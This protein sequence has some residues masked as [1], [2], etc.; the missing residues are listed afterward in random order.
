VVP[1]ATVGRVRFYPFN[2]GDYAAATR[3]LSL[4]EDLAYR[5]I[6]DAIYLDEKFP[7]GTPEEVAR[8][9]GMRDH[10]AEVRNVLAEFFR[11]D[12]GCWLNSRCREEINRYQS[13]VNGGRRGAA[14]RW[15]NGGGNTL[16]N[17]PPNGG[18]IDP[19][20]PTKNQDQEPR[21]KTKKKK[22]TEGVPEGVS[23]KVWEDF[24]VMRRA[25]HAPVTET[26]LNR[27][28]AEA[29][30]VGWTLEQAVTEMVARNWQGFRSDWVIRDRGNNKHDLSS[31]NYGAQEQ[32]I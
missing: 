4:L 8:K 21:T 28:V 13:Q 32:E 1:I 22:P 15:K 24:L 14:A 5:R 31:I 25:K 12:E 16:P 18:A 26:V 19:P 20:M 10:A 23:P 6:L 9:I 2:I 29:A 3:H 11:Q 17:T 30:K 27:I 7:A